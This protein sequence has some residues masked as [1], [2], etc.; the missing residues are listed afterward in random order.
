[1]PQSRLPNAPLGEVVFEVRF[2]GDLSLFSAW[3]GI[4]KAVQ[5]E[6]PQLLVP[7]VQGGDFPALKPF[8]LAAAD[9]SE[10]LTLAV[11]SFAFI[12][13]RYPEFEGFRQRYEPLLKLFLD[14]FQPRHV[15]RAGLRYLNWLPTE[16]PSLGSN[17][18]RLHPALKLELA[19]LPC[20]EAWLATPSFQGQQRHGDSLL[21]IQ[22]GPDGDNG[23]R[24]DFDCSRAGELP[25]TDVMSILD[26]VHQVIE[27][28][29]FALVTEEYLAYM[30]GGAS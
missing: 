10:R 9:D 26:G 17:P 30:K 21:T 1:M 4:Q 14:H 6:F 13:R 25:A 16:L 23:I 22:L 27:Q 24:L 11:N 12:T 8:H 20:E 3:G 7:K 19:G 2:P 29:F 5:R 18:R 28:A 15:T